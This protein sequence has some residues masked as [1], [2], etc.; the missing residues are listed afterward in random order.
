MAKDF[1]YQC[2]TCGKTFNSEQSRYCCDVCEAQNKTDQPPK[3]ILKVLYD[4]DQLLKQNST[5]DQLKETGFIDLLPIKQMSSLPPLKIGDTPLYKINKIDSKTLN[6]SLFLKDDSQNPTFSFKDRASALVSAFAR[7]NNF[8][9]IVVA[10]T[11]NAGSSMAGICAAAGQ[12]AYVIIPSTA[13][14]AKL[15]QTM[16]Y[17]AK[18]IPVKG[19]YD[20]CFDLS[21]EASKEYGWYNRNTAYNPLT[22]EGKKTVAFELFAQLEQ[23]LPDRIFIPTG[24]GVILAGVY[25]GFEDLVSL[26]LIEKIP[27]I[28]AVQSSGSSNLIDNIEKD[29]FIKKVSRTIA[30]S[31]S[32]DIPRNFFM[33]S[34]YLKNWHGEWIKVDDS[35]ILRSSKIL[36]RNTGLFAEPAASAAFA[37][38]LKYLNHKSI[39]KNSKNIVLLTGSG[40]KDTGSIQKAF[41]PIEPILPSIDE[42]TRYIDTY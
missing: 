36:A 7:E 10:S 14:P 42:I 24:D 17:G 3:G 4:Y 1:Y 15:I 9:D 8:N 37:G 12:N 22:I 28:V 26:K 41:S 39:D 2:T 11:G 38:F 27:V 5:F 35:E 40:L 31:I 21:I 29:L 32:V 33:A 6:C 23:N 34:G 13:P 16:M 25:K 30:D 20:D 18:L 19:N